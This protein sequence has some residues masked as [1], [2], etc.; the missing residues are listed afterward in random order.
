MGEAQNTAG[1][2]KGSVWHV[3]VGRLSEPVRPPGGAAM[4]PL[5]L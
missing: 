4:A 1:G 2:A 5:Q 3:L